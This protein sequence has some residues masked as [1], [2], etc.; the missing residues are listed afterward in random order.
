MEST[1]IYSDLE[2]IILKAAQK[3]FEAKGYVGARMQAIA[4]EAAISKASLHYYFRT[5]DRLFQK[6]FERA[7]EGYLPI[8]N[9]LSDDSLE[10]E[11]KIRRF[12]A[13]LFDFIQNGRM[14]FLIREINRDPEILSTLIKSK[15][16][17]NSIITYFDALQ[18]QEKINHTDSRLLYLFLNSLCCFPVINRGMFQKSM[19]M[20]NREY[21]T[22]M[23]AYAKSVA[24]FFIQAIKK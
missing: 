4:D 9:A 18:E 1:E 5:K 16:K 15:K 7:L 21:E 17:Q 13:A 2:E 6:V 3:E 22:L 24:D 19:R 8:V 14:L 11:E 12:T 23:H 20:T 10:W